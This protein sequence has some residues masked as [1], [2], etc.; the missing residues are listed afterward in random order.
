ML[1]HS[2]PQ[3]A[4]SNAHFYYIQLKW[5]GEKGKGEKREKGKK[6]V[7]FLLLNSRKFQM[8][9]RFP[10][11]LTILAQQLLS[12]QMWIKTSSPHTTHSRA[13]KMS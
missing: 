11:A 8:E 12:P 9:K 13:W 5:G 3:G 2:S 1:A 4:H 7:T 10:A 6:K